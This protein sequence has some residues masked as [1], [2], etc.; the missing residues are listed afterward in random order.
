MPPAPHGVLILSLAG[1]AMLAPGAAGNA[2]AA[3][4]RT[5][6][7]T[8]GDV[9]QYAVPAVG[10]VLSVARADRKGLG[11]L[12]LA[13]AVS[14]AVVY[15]LKPVVDRQRPNGGRHAFPSGHTALAFTGAAF[16]HR[17]YGLSHGL[18]AYAVSAFVGF[19]RI[20]TDEHWFSDVLAGAA[21]G[22]GANVLF[23]R[24]Y[25]GVSVAPA[26]PNGQPGL[27]ITL[28]W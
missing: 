21:I 12:A 16:L 22:V 24:R 4:A 9:G 8:L 17:R 20:Y 19:S 2:Q 26:A 5:T 11:Q 18:P 13:S 10:A 7:R 1:L 3:D 15:T 23:T 25:R 6:V 27:S 14:V 28:A